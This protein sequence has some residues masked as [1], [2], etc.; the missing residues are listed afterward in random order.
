MLA[1]STPVRDV[2]GLF[3]LGFIEDPWGTRIE[4]VQDPQKLGLH[5]VHLRAP[6]PDATLAWYKEAGWLTY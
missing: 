5:H 1:A 6:D 4:V 3:K 2:S